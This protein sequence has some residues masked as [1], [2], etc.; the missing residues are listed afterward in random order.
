MSS[1]NVFCESKT[2]P[3]NVSV[4]V[5]QCRSSALFIGS[6]SKARFLIVLFP[7]AMAAYTSLAL[8]RN[9]VRQKFFFFNNFINCSDDLMLVNGRYRK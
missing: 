5:S 4:T 6:L 2:F 3:P 9:L 7:A 1:L 8:D